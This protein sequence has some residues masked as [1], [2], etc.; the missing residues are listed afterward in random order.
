MF[1]QNLCKQL[2]FH[3]T[4]RMQERQKVDAGI[5][6]HPAAL[7]AF[8]LAMTAGAVALFFCRAVDW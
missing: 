8:Y 2:F 4:G 5:Q 1:E 6:R 3:Y 7:A